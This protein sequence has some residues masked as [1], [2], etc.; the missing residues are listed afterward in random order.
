[1]GGTPGPHNRIEFV[2]IAS[3]GN[4]TDFGD[5]T[6]ARR[7]AQGVSNKTRAVFI[8]GYTGSDTNLIDFVNIATTGNATDFGDRDR[9]DNYG[10]GA[11]S[12]SHGGLS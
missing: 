10:N 8:T 9:E 3:T 7:Y 12:D 6:L 5:L 1:M 4:A 11:T 2:T